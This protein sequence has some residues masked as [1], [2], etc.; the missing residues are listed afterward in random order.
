MNEISKPKRMAADIT[1]S[2]HNDDNAQG[3]WEE[4]NP[5]YARLV[6]FQKR[7]G[8]RRAEIASLTGENFKQDENGNWC[9]EVK[10]GKGG[11]YQL[12]RILPDD[13]A[14]VRAYSAA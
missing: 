6:A 5:K 11:K 2:R 13:V 1:R 9:V 8:I 12:Q 14:F 4:D 7:V 10:K 3:A